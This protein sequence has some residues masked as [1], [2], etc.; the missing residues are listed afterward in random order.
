MKNYHHRIHHRIFSPCSKSLEYGLLKSFI[1]LLMVILSFSG[2]AQ[3]ITLKLDIPP[4]TG[5]T[6]I[7]PFEMNTTTDI[8]TG[9]QT[10]YG[11]TVFCI[12]GAENLFVLATLTHSDSIRNKMGNAVPF[13]AYMA[14]RNDGISKPT[15]IDANYQAFFPLSNSGR[16]IENIK[17]SPQ[18]LNAFIF[19][20]ATAELPK[21]TRS[22]YVGF[23]DFNIE[24]N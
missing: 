10:L 18:V 20:Y 23:I 16:I 11:T 7:V 14:Y 5:Q 12:S 8:N 24:Y 6:Q 3:F 17:N 21:I 4:K 2:H 13:S 22:T 15:G 9:Q 1:M 19:I